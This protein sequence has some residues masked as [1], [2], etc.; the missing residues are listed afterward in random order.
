MAGPNDRAAVLDIIER[1]A[2]ESG[3]PRDDFLRFAYIETGG[4]FNADAH[5]RTSGAKGLFQFMP[6]TAAEFGLTGREFDAAANTDAAATLYARNRTQITNRS[7]ETGHAFLSGAESPNGLDMYLAHQQGGGGY[8]SIQRAIATG[9]FSRSDT[10]ANILGNLDQAEF[11]RLA[12]HPRGSISGL[13]DRDLAT[14]F[15]QYWTVKYAAIEIPDRGI[16]ASAPLPGASVRPDPLSDG[17]LSRSERGQ[18]V[19]ALQ[20][21]LNAL[22]FRDAQGNALETNSGIYGQRTEEAVRSFQ[23]A[24]GAVQTG[25]ADEATRQAIIDQLSRPEAERARAPEPISQERPG[26]VWPAPGNTRINEA[27]KPREGHGEFGTPRSGGRTHRGVDIQGEVGAPIVAFAGGVVVVKPDNRDAGN[28][29]HVRHDDGSVSKYFHLD[30]FSVENGQ[31][32]EAGQQI[33]TMGRT[34]NTPRYGDTH[35]HFELIRDGRHVDPMP[36]LRGSEQIGGA[37]VS[38]AASSAPGHLQLGANG[39]AVIALQEQL[40]QLGYQGEDGKPLETKSGVFGPQTDHALRAFQADRAIEVD[41]IYGGQSQA[42]IRSAT[43]ASR[44][45]GELIQ[46]GA[47]GSDVAELQARLHT[48]GYTDAS[49]RALAADGNFGDSTREAVL[50]LQRANNIQVDGIVGPETSGKLDALERSRAAPEQPERDR[51]EQSKGDFV[52]RMLAAAR[53]ADGL[54][55]RRLVDKFAETDLGQVWQKA[56]QQVDQ[57]SVDQTRS[58]P[59]PSR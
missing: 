6:S 10:R 20:E 48:L 49:G 21:S 31:R 18:E 55:I 2:T 47:R 12:G 34:G 52:Q 24:N 51:P 28:T 41:G 7:A 56:A 9:E 57:P 53:D 22:G 59:D 15:T 46:Q 45:S 30:G 54:D 13:S 14:S 33:G 5:N 35:L 26:A 16:V 19:R 37:D 8:A 32:V 17:V 38:R 25:Q 11:A 27:D 40:N 29:V 23:A 1:E 44:A 3:I 42:A 4:Q 50:N 43:E 39:A 36:Y 58:N